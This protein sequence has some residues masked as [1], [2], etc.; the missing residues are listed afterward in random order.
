MN[1]DFI[2]EVW[3]TLRNH[4]DSNDRND[5]ADSL[6][7]LLIDNNYESEDIKDA[8]R[9]DKEMLFALQGYIDHQEVEEDYENYEEEIDTD[10]WD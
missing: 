9:G 2:R 3:D 4:V 1:L 10:E 8:F 7:N 5:A 6:I